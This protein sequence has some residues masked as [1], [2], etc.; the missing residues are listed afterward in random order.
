MVTQDTSRMCRL[1]IGNCIYKAFGYIEAD[2]ET[3]FM[4]IST[5]TKIRIPPSNVIGIRIRETK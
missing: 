3:D 4:S 5:T 2:V 1:N